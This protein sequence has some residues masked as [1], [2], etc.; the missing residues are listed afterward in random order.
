[1]IQERLPSPDRY[2]GLCACG[3]MAWAVLT[4]GYVTFVSP[5]DAHHLQQR[6]WYAK[7]SKSKRVVYVQA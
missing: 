4:K 7:E 5:E 2:H 1:M 3:E 6:K